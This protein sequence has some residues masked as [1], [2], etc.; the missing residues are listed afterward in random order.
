MTEA[1]WH[2]LGPVAEMTFDPAHVVAVAD[3]RLAVYPLE[4]GYACLD[5]ICPHAGASI[6]DGWVYEGKAVCPLHGWEFDLRSGACPWGEEWSTQAFPIRE[7]DGRLE[8]LL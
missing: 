4:D 5:D 3:R 7:I 8:V 2:D 6:G 1:R